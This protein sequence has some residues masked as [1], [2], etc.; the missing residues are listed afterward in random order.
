MK[1]SNKI[2]VSDQAT[3]LQGNPFAALQVD[4]LPPGPAESDATPAAQSAS[5]ELPRMGEVILRREKSG[6]GG[7]TVVVAYGF[8]THLHPV[9]LERLTREAKV[10]CGCGGVCR[11]REIELQGD[12]I[13]KVR[14]FFAK[15]GFRLRGVAS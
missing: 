14:Q 5:S 8:A 12:I 1:S 4:G 11:D 6:R 2:P 10:A 9:E 15:R 7:K 3:P 13:P